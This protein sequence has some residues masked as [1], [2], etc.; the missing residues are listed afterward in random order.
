[1][2]QQTRRKAL[3]KRAL[4]CRVHAKNR[5]EQRYG[6]TLNRHDLFQI[7]ELVRSGACPVIRYKSGELDRTCHKVLYQGVTMFVGY[8]KKRHEVV[9]FLPPEVAEG[10]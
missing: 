1:M 5:V 8:D 6:I 9:T 10:Q 2:V 7:G 4:N 3:N